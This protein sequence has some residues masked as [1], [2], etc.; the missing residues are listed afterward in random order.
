MVDSFFLFVQRNDCHAGPTPRLGAHVP[1]GLVP[2]L[3]LKRHVIDQYCTIRCL[4]GC[5]T[6]VTCFYLRKHVSNVAA[7]GA[8]FNETWASVTLTLT[9]RDHTL[10]RAPAPALPYAYAP[11]VAR[12]LTRQP[13]RV[14][15][16][17]SHVVAAIVQAGRGS[18]GAV[19]LLGSLNSTLVMRN[20]SLRSNVAGSDGGAVAAG[21]SSQ[22]STVAYEPLAHAWLSPMQVVA[23]I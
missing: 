8:Q 18:G 20:S 5:V 1:S 14:K 16:L 22:V 19:S 15:M 11:A 17:R 3:E 23:T 6:C 12:S 13:T 7:V 9:Y 2:L 4:H 10:P 21:S